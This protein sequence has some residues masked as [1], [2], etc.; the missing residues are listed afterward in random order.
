VESSNGFAGRLQGSTNP[1]LN[2][3]KN[4]VDEEVMAGILM[5]ALRGM[6]THHKVFHLFKRLSTCLKSTLPLEKAEAH[7][8]LPKL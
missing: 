8:W 4:G 1:D 5:I 7:F 2:S 6:I 3:W